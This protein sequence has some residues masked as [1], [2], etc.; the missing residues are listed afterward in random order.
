MYTGNLRMIG[1][2]SKEIEVSTARGR[3][4]ALK[5][6]AEAKSDSIQDLIFT[7]R[8]LEGHAGLD[9]EGAA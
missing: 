5:A 2:T 7:F 4:P 3:Q 6:Q 8:V 1:S 9:L